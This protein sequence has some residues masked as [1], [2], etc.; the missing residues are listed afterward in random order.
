[1]LMHLC[2]RDPCRHACWRLPQQVC[3]SNTHG[4]AQADLFKLL[5]ASGRLTA[6]MLLAHLT[7][8]GVQIVGSNVRD[9]ATQIK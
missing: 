8:Y 3:V 5:S 9:L 1:M 7:W 2:S 6:H 4:Q